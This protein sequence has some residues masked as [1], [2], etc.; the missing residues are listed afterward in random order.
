MANRPDRI[1]KR[2]KR[3]HAIPINVAIPRTEMSRKRKWKRNSN[4][5]V[6]VQ[7]YDECGT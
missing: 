3:K 5:R 4:T 6:Y 1:I 7:R 2:Q